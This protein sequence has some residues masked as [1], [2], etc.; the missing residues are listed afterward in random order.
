MNK[1]E[2]LTIILLICVVFSLQA[3]IAAD[4]GSNSTDSTVL[5]VDENVSS[6]AL[7][8]SDTDTL[9][10]VANADSFTNLSGQLSGVSE[11][12]LEKN[13]TYKEGDS[14]SNGITISHDILIDGKGNVII[15]ANHQSRVFIIAEGATVTLKGITFINANADSHGGS[16]WAKGVVHIDNCKFINNTA[17]GANGGAV[18]VAGAGSTITD[19]YF[20]GNRATMNPNNMNTGAAG[21]VFIN[22]NNT[23]ITNSEFVR[24]WAGLNGGGVG[25]SANRIE[26]CNI[27]N[28]EFTSNTANGSA[29]AIG[30]QSRNFHIADSTFKYNEAKGIFDEYP[31]NGGA[32]VMRGWDS[33]AY[34]CTFIDNIASNHGGAVFMTNTSYDP[35][36]NNT[37]VGLSTFINNTAGYNGGAIDWAAGA[38]HGYIEDSI[39]TNNTAKRSGGAV[40]WSGYYGDIIN[41]TFTNNT[42]T[43]EVISTI[44]GIL[45]GG[46]GG[47][48]LWVGSHGIISECN[49]TDNH[50]VNR[51]GAIYLHGNSTENCTNITV[52]ACRFI[53]NSAGINGGAVDWHDGSNEGSIYDSIFTNNTA[54]SNGGAVFWSGHDGVIIGSNFTNNT[55]EGRLVDEHGNI[56]DG[57]AI[58]W[59]GINGTVNYCRFIGNEAKFNDTYDYGG[60]GGAIYLQNCT[61]GNCDNTTFDNVYFESNVAG[62]NGGAIDW[63]E[64]AHHGLVENGVFIN[65][66]A[67]RSGGAI[68]WNGHNG[69]IIYSKFYDNKALGI[70][71]ALSVLGEVTYGGDGGAVIW[72]GALGDIEKCNFVNNTAAKRGGAIYLQHNLVEDCDNTTFIDTYFAR[73]V[74][75]TNGGAIDWNEGAH[76]GNIYN[77]TFIENIAKSNGG[78]V[79]WSG[80]HGEIILS[81]FTN[82]IAKG[83]LI[84]QHGNYGDGGAIIWS[85][86]NGTVDRCRFINNT[87]NQRGGAV[88]LQN[89]THGNCDNTTFRYSIF[90][91]NTAGLNGG[92]I[93]W[94]AGAS[95]GNVS[96]CNFENNIANRSAGAIYWSGHNGTVTYSNFTHNKALGI[97]LGPMPNGTLTYGGDAGAVM[98]TGAIGTVMG[99]RFIENTAT[100]RGGAVFLQEGVNKDGTIENCENTTF[101]HSIFI[102]NVAGLNGGAI[103]WHAGSRNG[104]VSYCSFENN[105]ANRSAGAIYWSGF[106]G[107][108]L[109]SNFTANKAL[110]IAIGPMPNGTMTYGG[111]AGAV[112]WT[113]ALG[114]VDDCKFVDNTATQRGGAVF[115][116]AGLTAG[117]TVENCEN[118]TFT[119]SIF[120]NNIAGLNG[121]AIE[122][123]RGARN[124]VVDNVTFINNTARRSGG[125]IFW[126]GINGTVKNSRFINNRATGETL[127]YDMELTMDDVIIINSGVLPTGMEQGKLYVLN[128]TDN[129]VRVFK[130]YV[131]DENSEVIQLDETTTIS[132][133]ISPKDWAIDQFFGGDGGT[134]LWSGDI[135]LVNNCTFVDSNSAR[136]GGGAYMTGSSNVTFSNCDF[137]KCTSGTNGGGVDWLA[138]AIYGK[139]INCTFNETR[140]ARSAGAIYYDGWYGQMINITIINTEAFGG[141]ISQSD[142][143]LVKYA[144]WDSSHWDTNTTGGDAGAIMITGSYETLY[145]I[146][147]INCIATGRGGAI[148]LQDNH[149]V[150]IDLCRFE[151]NQ[152]LGIAN[153]TYDNPRDVSS[154]QNEWKTGLGGAVGFDLG[155][156]KGTIKNSVFINNTAA[157]D[158]GAISFAYGS[159]YA[160]IF[161]SSFINNTAKRSGGAFSWNGNEGNISYCNFTGNKALGIAIDTDHA[162]LTGLGQVIEVT[163]LPDA[164]SSTTNKLYVLVTYEGTTKTKYELYV[165]VSDPKGGYVWKRHLES[166]V[167]APS[168]TDWAI[169]EYFGGDGGSIIWGGDHGTID[170]CIFIDSDS[171]RRGGAAYMLGSDYVTFSNC[172]FENTTSGTNGGGLDWLAG[173]NYGKVVDCIFN[174][175]EA[176]RSAGAIYYDG[177]YGEFRNIIIENSYAHGGDL[178]ISSDGKVHYA[179]WDSSHWDTNTTG[180]DAGAIMITGDHVYIY[181]ATFTNCTAVGRGG[182][183][184]LQDNDNVTFDLCTFENNRALGTANNTYN[185]ARDTDSGLNKWYTGNGG[186]VG[187]DKG[188]SNGTIINSKFINNTAA[189]NG[190]AVSFSVNSTD[191]YIFNSSFVNNT[192]YRSGGALEWDGTNGYVSYCNFTGN[193]ALGTA[194][195]TEY[196]VLTSLSNVIEVTSL[197]KPSIATDNKLYVRVIYDGDKKVKYELWV[198]QVAD[199]HYWLQI[200]E[201]TETG[202]SAID[203]A[204]DEYY[205]GDGGSIYWAGDNA[206]I[207]HCIFIDSNSARRGGGAYMTGGD[208]VEYV[209]CTFENCTSGTNGGGLDWLAGANYGKVIDC[210]FTNTEAARSAGAIY[211]D[212]DYGEFRNIIIRNAT[213]HGGDLY[214]SRDGKVHYAGWDSSHWDTNTT[215]GDAG[216]IM[217]TGDH[218]YLYNVNIT[219]STAA[220]RGGA[221][222]VQDNDNVTFESCYFENNRALGTANNTYNDPHDTSSGINKTLT[223]HGGAI[224]FDIGATHSSIIGSTFINNTAE[225]YGGAVHFREGAS[226]DMIINSSFTKNHANEDGGALFVTGFDCELHN[227][228]FYDNYA[229]DD[230]GAIYWNGGDGIIHNIT[231]VNNSGISSHGNSKGGTLCLVGDNMALSDSTFNQ[232]YAKVTGGAIFATGNYVNITGCDFYDCNVTNSTGGGIQILGNHILVSDCT[233]EECHAN[234]GSA[235]YAEGQYTRIVNSTFTHNN[236]TED[237][238]AVYVSGDYSELHNST[239]TYNLAG[240]DGGAIYWEGDHGTI[241]N[242]TCE[243]NKGISLDDSNSNGG[244]ICITGN[245]IALSDSTFKNSSAVAYGGAIYVTGN[246]V[247][248]TGSEFETCNS[249]VQGG[250]IYILGDQTLISEC[251]FEDCNGTQGGAIY[252]E[253]NDVTIFANITDTHAMG[254]DSYGITVDYKFY[255]DVLKVVTRNLNSMIEYVA[256][257]QNITLT[258]DQIANIL[259]T[260]QNLSVA[261]ENSLT[262]DGTSMVNLTKAI[263]ILTELDQTLT[264]LNASMPEG[265]NKNDIIYLLDGVKYIDGEFDYI[266]DIY[267]SAD[268]PSDLLGDIG[269]MSRDVDG[270]SSAVDKNELQSALDNIKGD[271]EN[272]LDGNTFS[273]TYIEDAL[274]LLNNLNE[275]LA[276][277]SVSGND[278]TIVN[279]LI[280]EVKD[281]ASKLNNLH[282]IVVVPEVISSGGAIYVSGNGALINN[283]V[284]TSTDAIYGGAVFISGDG[285][286][287]DNSVV[288]NTNAVYGGGIYITGHDVTVDHSDFINLYATEDGGA[289]YITG[290]RGKLYNSKFINNTAGDD[291]GAINWDGN[292]GTINNIT[293]ENNKGISFNGSSSN[294]GTIAL[295]G[296]D[297]SISQSSFKDTY[298]LISGG[299]IFVTGNRV[300]ITDSEFE[301]C[302]VSMDIAETGKNYTNGGGAIYLLGDSSNVVNCTFDNSKAREGGVIYVQGNNITIDNAKSTDSFALNGGAFYVSGNHA[303]ISNSTIYDSN[304]SY[305][306][307]AVFIDGIETDIIKSSFTNTNAFGS[308][309]NGGGAIFIKGENADIV[310]SNFTNNYANSNSHAKGGAMYITGANAEVVDSKFTNAHSNI[311]GG[312]IYVNGTNTIINGS[313]F[314]ECKVD[315]PGSEGGS[316]YIEGEN[317]I[318]EGSNFIDSS[319]VY[320]G[321]AI[322]IDG[323]N[324]KVKDSNFTDSSVTGEK[325]NNENPRGGAIYI[326]AV[327][328]VVEGS[329]F[330]HSTVSTASGEG[331]AIFIEG[332]RAKILG[333]EFESSS[334]NTGGAIYLQ[335][336][337]VYVSASS[338]N[339]SYAESSGGALYSK[340]SNSNVEH[341][342]FTNNLVK[343]NGG[344]LY[345]SGESNSKYNTVDGCIFTNNT[346]YGYTTHKDMTRGGGA[347]YWSEGGTRGTVKNSKFYYNSVQ[348]INKKKVDGGAIL[349]DKSYH[350]L[351]ENCI[352]VGNF[353]T[354]DGEDSDTGGTGVW[355]QG[356]AMYLRPNANYTVRNCLFENCSSSKEAG[357]L[358]IQGKIESSDPMIL[359]ENSVFINNVAYAIG[360]DNNKKINGGGAIQ[361][362]QCTNAEFNNL[363]FINNT[364][365]KGGA[366]CVFDKVSNLV[367]DGANFTGNKADRGS[368]ISASVSFTLK[369]AVLLENRANTDTFDLTFNRANAGSIDILLKGKDNSLNAMYAVG[370][371]V[372]CSN[373]TYWTNDNKL[374]GKTAVTSSPQAPS[375]KIVPEAG[376]SIT[377][378]L[379]DANNNKLN[380]GNDIFATDANGKLH[381]TSADFDGI[382]SFDGVY[383]VARLTNED[384]YTQVIKTTRLATEMQATADNAIYH[385]NATAHVTITRASGSPSPASGIVSVYYGDVFLGNITITNNTGVSDEILTNITAD[386]FLEVGIHNLTFRYWGDLY[387]DAVNL[388]VPLNVTK[389]QSNITFAF[390]EMGYDLFTYVT[391]VDEWNG[392]Y[393]AD[394]NGVVTLT[395]YKENSTVPLQSKTIHIFEGTGFTFFDL[396]P[397]NYTI[398]AEY[399]GDDNYNASVNSTPAELHKKEDVRILIDI[400]ATDIMVDEEVYINITVLTN[401]IEATGNITL[402]LDNEKY[403]L[404]LNNNSAQ[405]HVGNLTAG[406]KIVI[407]CYDGSRDLQANSGDANFTVHKYNTT[408]EIGVTNITHNQKEIINIT[409]LNETTGVVYITVDGRNYSAVINNRTA[410]LELVNLTVGE[411]NVTVT[412]PGDW[413][414]NNVTNMTRFYVNKIVPEVIIDVDNVTYGNPTTVVI[415]VPDCVSGNVTIKV[416]GQPYGEAKQIENGKVVFDLGKLNA[417]EYTL[418]AIYSGDANHTGA[419]YEQ[420]FC[421]YKDNRTIDIEVENII[422]GAVEHI[423]VHVNATGTVTI[424]V[425]GKSETVT[426]DDNGD[427]R[428]NVSGLAANTYTVDVT[429][430]GN[431][432]YNK[433]SASKEF[434][435]SKMT[436]SLDVE[437]HDVFVRDMEYINITVRNS[438]GDVATDL[439]GILTIDVDGVSR[440]VN[441]VNG[442]AIFYTAEF[443]KVIGKRTVWAFFDGNVNF[444]ASRDKETYMVNTRTLFDDEWNVTARDIYVGEAGNITVN[445]PKDVTGFVEIEVKAYDNYRD[446]TYYTHVIDGVAVTYPKDLREGKYHVYVTYI[447]TDY[448]ESFLD[449][450]FTVSKRNVNVTIDVNDT[451]YDNTSD[452]VVYVDD[453][454]EGSITIRIGDVV[455]GTYGI[456]DGKVN[457]TV[458]L[459]AGTYTVYAEYNGN[460]M[461]LVNKT[462]SKGFTVY[463]ATPA[464]TIDVPDAVD[465]NAN[466]TIVVR[467]NQTATGNITLTVNGTRYNA[468][469]ENGVAVFVID[470]LLS[471]KYNITAEYDG[472]RNYTAAAVTLTEGLTVDKVSCYQINVTAND[473]KVGWNSTITVRVPADAV[474]NVSIYVDGVFVENVTVLQGIAQLNVTRPYGNH[475]VNV[476]FT[477]DKYGFRYAIADFW[478]FK[479]DSPLVIDVDSVLV[480]D[481]AYINVTAPSDNVT[482]EINGVTYNSLRYEDGIAYFEVTGLEHGN[483]TVVAIYGGS[484]KYV[485][486]TTTKGFKVSKRSSQVN[487]TVNATAVGNDVIINVTIPGDA[488]GYVIVVVDGQNYSINTTGGMGS[489]RIPGLGNV[490]HYVNVTYAGDEQYLPSSNSTSF[491]LSKVNS[492]VSVAGVNITLGDVE[493]ITVTVPVDATGNVTV[494]VVGIGTYTIAVANGT[495]ILVVKDLA[496]GTYT[497]NVCY[498]GDGKYLSNNNHT[499]FTVSRVN[500]TADDIMVIDQGNGTVV[501]IVPENATG[502]VTITVGNH[503]YVANVTNGTAVIDLVNETPG[504]HNITVIYSGDGNYTN[505][506][507][508][509]TVSIPKLVPAIDVN[510][511]GIYV[512]DVALINVTL[513]KDA[514]GDVTIE[515]N[516]IEYAPYEF[517]NGVAKFRV[518]DLAFGVKTVAVSYDGDHNYTGISTTANFTVSKRSSQVNVTVNATTVGNDVVINVTIPSDA[519]GYVVVVVDGQNYSINTTNGIGSVTIPGLGNA[520]HNV[521]VTYLGD[522]KYLSSTNGT[523]FTLNKVNSTVSVKA[524]NITLGDVEF[525][526]ISVPADASGNVTVEVVGVGTYTVPVVNGTA[527]LVVKDLPAGTY[528]VNVSYNGDGKYL[529]NNNHTTF[530]VSRVNTTED[531]IMVIDQGNGTVVVVVPDN[532][533]GNVTIKVGN[534]TYVANITNGTAV[535]DLVNETPGTHNIT[536]IYSGDGNYTNATLN[537][538]VSIS[539]MVPAIN[540]NVTDIYVGDVALINVTLPSNAVGAVTIEINGIEYAPYEFTNGVAKFR[541]ENLAFGVKTVAVVY[542]GDDNYT[543]ISATANFTVSKRSSQVNVTVNATTVGK[544]VVIN[545]TIPSDATGYVVVVVD[546]QN[547]SINTTN[548]IGSVTI[549][550]LGN[551]THNVNVTY[552]GDEKYLSSTNGTSFTLNKVNSTVSVK[553][554][555][556]TLGDVE[557]ITIS[558]PADASGNV[559]VEVVGVGTYTV[560]VADGTGS[561][562][563]K[564][565]AVGTYTVNVRYNGDGKYLA[566]TNSTTFTVSRVNTTADDI[567]VID[568]GNGTVVVVVPENATGNVTVKIGNNTYVANVTNGTAVIDLVNETPGT[569]EIEVIYSGDGNY[570]NVTFN[571]T[572][573][574]PKLVP[575]IDVNVTSIYV[576]D[577]ELINVTLPKDATGDVTIEI[578]GKTYE[579]YEFRDGIARFKVENLTA[580]VKTVAVKYSGDANYTA[581]F[582]TA[583]FTVSKRPSYVRVNVSD[584]DVGQTAVINITIPEN[585][586]GQVIVSVGGNNYTINMTGS[587][588][589]VPIRFLESGE[590]NIT[591]TYMGNDEY[592][593]SINNTESF[594]VSKL[595]PVFTVTGTNITYGEPEFIEILTDSNITGKV[596][597]EINGKNYSTF[598]NEG[599][600][601][602]TIMG[603]DA[604]KYNITAY[605]DGNNKYLNATAKNNFTISKAKPFIKVV[606]QN[607]TF[608][609]KEVITVYVNATGKVNITVDGTTYDDREI[610]NGKVELELLG[611]LCAG[612]YTADVAYSGNGNY[613]TDYAHANF[614]VAKR[615]PSI[616]VVVQNITYGGVE[617]IIVYVNASGNVTIKVNGTEQNIILKED[618]TAVVIL[619]ATIDSLPEFDGRAHEYLYNLNAGAYP[620]EVIYHGNE[621]Y[622][623][624]TANTFFLVSKANTTVGIEVDNITAKGREIINV[625]VN[626]ANA[627]GNVTINVDG[628]NHTRPVKD[629]IA[630]LV[631]DNVGSGN[632][633]VVAIYEGDGNLNGNWSSA[634]FSASKVKPE[635]NVVVN[636]THVGQSE[637]ITVELPK[638]ATGYVVIDVDGTKYHVD[639]H[640]GARNV[641]IEVDG[642]KNKTYTVT[643]TYSGDDYY[644]AAN[645]TDTFSVGRLKAE[646]SV[647]ADNI[648]YG[649]KA[650]ITVTTPEDLYGNVTVSVNGENH[651]VYVSGGHGT[652]VVPGLD[653]GNYPVDVKFAGNEKYEPTGNSTEFKV[654]K[655]ETDPGDIKIIDQNN[656]TVVVV[657]PGNATGNVTIKVGDDTFNATV[658]DGVATVTLGNVT[659]GTHE[660]EVVYSGDGN[661]TNATLKSEIT[662]PKLTPSVSI[663]V[664]DIKVGDAALINVTLPGDAKGNVTVEIDGK[665]YTPY[666]FK[667]GVARFKVENL[668]SGIKTVAVRY[669]GD[670]NYTD[671]FDTANFTVSKRQSSIDVTVNATTVGNDVIINVTIPSNATGYVI[672]KVDGQNYSIN[673]T[674]GVGSVRISGLGNA[675]H[676]V[677]VTYLGDEQY[678]PSTGGAEFTLDKVDSTVSA[679]GE[680]ITVGDKEVITV[681][682]PVDATGNVTVEIAGVG[683]FT[684]PVANGTGILVV[685]DLKAGTYDVNVRYNGDGKYLPSDSH[686]TFKVSKVDTIDEDIKVIDQGNG[687][688]VVVVPNN[689]TGNVTVKVGDHT[690]VANVTNGTAVIQLDNEAPGTHD[691][692]VVYSGDDKYSNATVNSSVTVPKLSASINVD[693]ANIQVGDAALINVTLPDDATGD[694]TIEIDGKVYTPYEFKDGVARFKVENL[695]SGVKTVVVKY[696]GDDNYISNFTTSN[697]TVS[698]RSSTVSATITDANVGDNVTVTVSVPEDATG[699]VLIDIDGVGYYV[700]VTGGK[701]TVDI[702]RIP[703]GVYPVNLTYTGD[704]K[705][706]PSHS[707]GSFNVSK[708]ASFVIPTAQ[709]IPVGANE[710]I[711]IQVPEDATGNVTLIIDGEEYVFNLND[712]TLGAGYSGDHK[713]SIAVSGGKGSI[714]INGLP[715]GE[716]VVSVKYNGDDK[717]LQSSNTTTFIV[718]KDSTDMEIKDLGNGTVVVELPE[719]AKGNVTVTIDNQTYVVN[720]TNGTAVID[721]V[722]ATPGTHDITVRY[723]GDDD[724]PPKTVNSTVTI[725]KRSTPIRVDVSDIYVGDTATVTVHLPDEATG[726]VEIEINGKKY[727]GEAKD[728]K[729]VIKV[730][731]LAFGDKT[732]AVT[733]GG[734]KY[735]V[736]NFTTAQFKVLQRPSS[737]SASSVNV[738]YGNDGVITV[739]VPADQTGRVLVN[740]NG[741]GYYATI[742]NGKAKV[743]VPDLAVGSYKVTVTY[744]GDDKYLP[745]TTTTS[746]KVTKSKSSISST[747]DVITEGENA[748]VVI[749]VPKGAKGSVTIKVNGKKYTA[750]VKN[751]K[752]RFKVSGLK[753]GSYKVHAKY[754][755]DKN[756][757]PST[758]TTKIVVHKNGKEKSGSKA[759]SQYHE[760][761]SLEKHATGNPILILLLVILAL[762]STQ[763]RRFKK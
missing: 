83:E 301:N 428:L 738:K 422:Y 594:T 55:A 22:A 478:V 413:K 400:N 135:G 606:P 289:I 385:R 317:T 202:P 757:E 458:K 12:T 65:N 93:D 225:L 8:S 336:N 312:A 39:F 243:N 21:A 475:T 82:N 467:I 221:V 662:V 633:S 179:G 623:E 190:G 496:V 30:M 44:G 314:N 670:D 667:D 192:A 620:V 128:Y 76:N 79:F 500:A 443:N 138:G 80:H 624:A 258:Q 297:T 397:A 750:K 111:D 727:A 429:Y 631:L 17:D 424:R 491:T 691:I 682:V 683:T 684:I 567:R 68:F 646:I 216:A 335:G 671:A 530:T 244:T 720:V 209:N 563:V 627:T 215:G 166:D 726:E 204:M 673:T 118:T 462:E 715:K 403:I 329:I 656:G 610:I 206:T 710:F 91:N 590:Y 518:A 106:N 227:S 234:Y 432:N 124:G 557:V 554:E 597:L 285:A 626:N 161:N 595:Q 618:D 156:S 541:V 87:A 697:F 353:V 147:F 270:L 707:N 742:K 433:S 689:A 558:V 218:I 446:D 473:T 239:F 367:V 259:R 497:V 459:G 485:Q 165:T 535:I 181:N 447:G 293:C 570:T 513:P 148:F 572:V 302:N 307:G 129:G 635:I 632:H 700:N 439:N 457:T 20:E 344:A 389:A 193:D 561:L 10:E 211:Y 59:S 278:K 305:S 15:D 71:N 549:P 331:G 214:E 725:P 81:N 687:T 486:N 651:T 696:S 292:Y 566:N 508:N 249:T 609:D 316:I 246:R 573:S 519:T 442:K 452:I 272:I 133:T 723:S 722:N 737:V 139:I 295:T 273:S 69:T 132:T 430:N 686:A 681:K 540:V 63:H 596:M 539:K 291:G 592:L 33:Y 440:T 300:N 67:R 115:L 186:A 481:V 34:N 157:R 453:G 524:E 759:G 9:A 420:N 564:D 19:S 189:R 474:G 502:N 347:I 144:G 477:D 598:I 516:G 119:N 60:R 388:T 191:A 708:V 163:E 162:I 488:V 92:A 717:Y 100:Q 449:T 363:T 419:S 145:N 152:A 711:T 375:S 325:Y 679:V 332:D 436:T 763:I 688:V 263:D 365:N 435:V 469:I 54:G 322:Y 562:V 283:S 247:N 61:H 219:D 16:I 103:D 756:H 140:A 196:A 520:T 465:A 341:S 386:K 337:N 741:I 319:A 591:V 751:G 521:N 616:R 108:I 381:L 498:N 574:I 311:Q 88:Y 407:V 547:Y 309:G 380:V 159:S 294:G 25:S 350:A 739:T 31:G 621:N 64:G 603:L 121:G 611:Y 318:I 42:A 514:T 178:K 370:A 130:S 640:K 109:H 85:G 515:I 102:G 752:A 217:I 349:W 201:T 550:G 232:S 366:L 53:S 238:G 599:R 177:D 575:A 677:S 255:K 612:N 304:A 434:V 669:S 164:N 426:L 267:N 256:N 661:H 418:E 126:N 277:L 66:T 615:D 568:K 155:A 56:G 146:T 666:E 680:N 339:G 310:E 269:T 630:T 125:A 736:E 356:G 29:G 525:I 538:T 693:T 644:E 441:V 743:V 391:I 4:S 48:V 279:K 321:G 6:Y 74:A 200:D 345:W 150:T 174:N 127:Q 184:F 220:G 754:S 694:V 384:Y 703:S 548:G 116:Q 664:D 410:I 607:I 57:G 461:Y 235:I 438:T 605:F 90:I 464:I 728:G 170:H 351:V 346:A 107:T 361:I 647:S 585:A 359:L 323:F 532:A 383:V 660:I 523:S 533:T 437:V 187:F 84:D 183:V 517:T 78:A 207:D 141:S 248:I 470:K 487:L 382:S 96:Y 268:V 411:H 372:T 131:V 702:P 745:S 655:I 154:G 545:V 94:H 376:I 280:G 510:V 334:A 546:G 62:T 230:G 613:G 528:T 509:S 343:L 377:V 257:M 506:T 143:G 167:T 99:C 578:D 46:D 231:C 261:I 320:R 650:V 5:S 176:A 761:T 114:I 282:G 663:S 175:T 579:P 392:K 245:D 2:I 542:S 648:T 569:H 576:G 185:N 313:E 730:S 236:A 551:A 600:G 51:G 714:T 324:A 399:H 374:S 642:L 417:G 402:Y 13:Y 668:T 712:G 709:D 136:R 393:Y 35:T 18:C 398:I 153:N 342:N 355:A 338:V 169:D 360:D 112:M 587:I 451:V 581:K 501:V 672:V 333:S 582:T 101:S 748:D 41:S 264:Q 719:D 229:G 58:I 226:E 228:T 753:A 522:E 151:N 657:V 274:R 352:F 306:G 505:V 427:A 692:E 275:T 180:G 233:L 740:V 253:G 704:D 584:I 237:G 608:G 729:A 659:P 531:D 195:S 241:N 72:S 369:N 456:V 674:G 529:T 240:D 223:G 252:V 203:W 120:I 328:A 208:H 713:Y 171:A 706:L 483:K 537:A 210:N 105:I 755:G 303:V 160:T 468:T 536:V 733:Y 701:G 198:S 601:N 690:Y 495:G 287:I 213:A 288:N 371:T 188:A 89:C 604:G 617:H 242:I 460:Y 652:L 296:N 653:V 614:T 284:I 499:Q 589:S 23:S 330:T 43:G 466:A 676:S 28:C 40:H 212:G 14:F 11:V 503:T 266:T 678:M 149:D 747:G 553:A 414:Y 746:F 602:L 38:T 298:A 463:K 113:G 565:L 735:Y 718:Y 254:A 639:I 340:G 512:G 354:T 492:T 368:A 559:T 45:G 511:T 479:H 721:L 95:H 373:V 634:I 455:I 168:A 421:V 622:N 406:D 695:T 348:S 251:S 401:G 408:F 444:T 732:V 315:T 734:D 70:V 396:L 760:A 489:L 24:N 556:I 52:D 308:E 472:D 357:A 26:N 77:S 586:T 98:W 698:K 641:T 364:A 527:T 415:D 552:L 199:I 716:Y 327:D 172:Y 625:T 271:V 50:A 425:N 224:S 7:P 636:D 362:K 577:A 583:N 416:N 394:A 27:V 286:I 142:D 643:A 173:A 97:A 571:S 654:S 379:F 1:K 197:P 205:G 409:F 445:L 390:D 431:D 222:F 299:A 629:G 405:I 645:D 378:E 637:K 758:S 482:I 494:E 281:A 290:Q 32:M 412:F 507:L 387:N 250:A 194:I 665:V 117:G 358:Y 36:N 705:Y 134:I 555:N 3:V 685:K 544:D 75:G 480:G 588:G 762:G 658:V 137:T 395:I 265:Q 423:K 454:V 110:G 628:V 450:H 560:P 744:E 86:I 49:F 104:N 123:M 326:K 122:W 37:G 649:D 448:T 476:T 504:T 260:L 526:T 182:A 262:D 471:G 593:S 731:G 493:I 534:N 47:A 490:T 73:N 675:T 158:G 580:G 724:Y 276:G 484:E 699:Q 404:P 638:N 619:R 749:D 543:G